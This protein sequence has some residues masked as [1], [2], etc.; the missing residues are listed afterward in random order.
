M[1]AYSKYVSIFHQC[2]GLLQRKTAV[3]ECFPSWIMHWSNFDHGSSYKEHLLYCTV[4]K[5]NCD[6]GLV[7]LEI[8]KNFPQ[9]IFSSWMEA[10]LCVLSRLDCFYGRTIIIDF[11][12]WFN[13]HWSFGVRPMCPRFY[14]AMY[15]LIELIN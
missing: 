12:L 4:E 7:C 5:I 11:Q 3:G 2:K 1:R 14:M 15:K 13:W 8:E 9:F 10:L 6:I